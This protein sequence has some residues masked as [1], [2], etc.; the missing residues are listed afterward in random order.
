[1][2]IVSWMIQKWEKPHMLE[3]GIGIQSDDDKAAVHGKT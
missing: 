2:F 1:M 3:D